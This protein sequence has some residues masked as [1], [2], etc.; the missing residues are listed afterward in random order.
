LDGA[1]VPAA[2][3]SIAGAE[4]RTCR[5]RTGGALA[6]VKN[7]TGYTPKIHCAQTW[8]LSWVSN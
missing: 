2:G 8:N 6:L 5:S 1:L 3:R 7:Q 4:C